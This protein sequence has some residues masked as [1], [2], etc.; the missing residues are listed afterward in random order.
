[1]DWFKCDV[2]Y[3][4]DDKIC[5]LAREWGSDAARAFWP[6]LL[7]FV[8]KNMDERC[9]V[10]I[11]F[12]E[13][14]SA[15]RSAGTKN[16]DLEAASGDRVAIDR[17]SSGYR[18]LNVQH[19]SGERSLL[20]LAKS[21]HTHPSVAVSRL[22]R[23]AIVGLMSVDRWANDRVIFIPNILKRLGIAKKEHALCDK[24][25]PTDIRYKEKK[26]KNREEQ[27]ENQRG[28]DASPTIVTAETPPP[29]P[30]LVPPEIPPVDWPVLIQSTF[31]SLWSHYPNADGRKDAFKH[32]LADVHRDAVDGDVAALRRLGERILLAMDKY[33]GVLGL[34]THREYDRKAKQGKT[35]FN[36]WKDWEFWQERGYVWSDATR[37]WTLGNNGHHPSVR[38][39]HQPFQGSRVEHD[40]EFGHLFR[41]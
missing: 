28:D 10:K 21:L 32:F 22:D 16:D 7:S 12:P 1:M 35:W 31:D 23:V 30:I 15:K 33:I 37:T 4:N 13:P 24:K 34:A 41:N 27:K 11:I 14:G 25:S 3:H 38:T 2:D 39:S 18:V 26:D 5:Q 8:Y 9:Q 36:N 17:R 40:D 6:M 29:S 20:D 19:S